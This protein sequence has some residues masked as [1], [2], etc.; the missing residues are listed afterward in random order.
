MAVAS[1]TTPG[2][3]GILAGPALMGFIAQVSN[4]SV[5]LGCVAATMLCVTVCAKTVVR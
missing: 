4:L 2:Y 3:A 1:V 5:A